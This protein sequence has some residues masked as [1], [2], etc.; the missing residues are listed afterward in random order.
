MRCQPDDGPGLYERDGVPQSPEA[1]GQRTEGV[2][3]ESVPPRAFDLAADDDELLAM[4]QLL[5]DPG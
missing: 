1:S 2:P 3:I 5:G 4:E